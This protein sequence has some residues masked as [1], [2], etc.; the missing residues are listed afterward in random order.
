[1]LMNSRDVMTVVCFQNFWEM[2]LVARDQ[3]IGAGRVGTEG[4][5]RENA[6]IRRRMSR[7]G[8]GPST[9]HEFRFAKLMLRSG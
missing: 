8:R 6:L 5:P 3:V 1:M 7:G 2:P 9:P 4:V